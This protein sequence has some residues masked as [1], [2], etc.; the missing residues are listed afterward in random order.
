[1]FSV[2]LQFELVSGGDYTLHE[3]N[4]NCTKSSFRRIALT[5]LPAI[6]GMQV[7]VKESRNTG[8]KPTSTLGS[9]TTAPATQEHAAV[10]EKQYFC[11]LHEIRKNQQI[12]TPF[13]TYRVDTG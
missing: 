5:I 10:A 1:V 8:N 7:G 6:A 9:G 2:S 12:P 4:R 3:N 13:V 11:G